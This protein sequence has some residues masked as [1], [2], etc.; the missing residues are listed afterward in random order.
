MNTANENTPTPERSCRIKHRYSTRADAHHVAAKCYAERGHWLR[1]YECDE[2]RGW[3]LTHQDALPD[4]GWRPPAR[5][6]NDNNRPNTRA[7]D[8]WRRRRG[9]RGKASRRYGR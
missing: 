3:H 5:P 9:G 6:A 8:E 7:G 1:V 2:C 4:P